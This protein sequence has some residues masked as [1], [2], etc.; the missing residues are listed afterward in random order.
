MKWAFYQCCT[1]HWLNVQVSVIFCVSNL[2]IG[3]ISYFC[4]TGDP[5][6]LS[7]H[8]PGFFGPC[9]CTKSIWTGKRVLKCWILDISI[10][11]SVGKAWG[12]CIRWPVLKLYSQQAT[13]TMLSMHIYMHWIWCGTVVTLPSD[14]YLG[15]HAIISNYC[16]HIIEFFYEFPI[17]QHRSTMEGVFYTLLNVS[18]SLHTQLSRLLSRVF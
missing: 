16:R 7:H 14:C 12:I 3:Y 10:L 13:I 5:S 17:T 6:R 2:D 8:C 4:C 18:P 11:H 15:V 9:P 1:G